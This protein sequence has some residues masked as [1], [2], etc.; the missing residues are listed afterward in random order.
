MMPTMRERIIQ[1]VARSEA[2]SS[3]FSEADAGVFADAVFDELAQ[4][5]DRMLAVMREEIEIGAHVSVSRSTLTAMFAAAIR[6]AKEE[7]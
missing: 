2:C 4:P 1:A 6:A 3:F 7:R 5:T